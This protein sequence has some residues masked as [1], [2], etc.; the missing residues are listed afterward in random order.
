MN[1]EIIQELKFKITK[2]MTSKAI[3]KRETLRIDRPAYNYL[4]G[5]K[6]FN[7]PYYEQVPNHIV[8]H[9]KLKPLFRH[10]TNRGQIILSDFQIKLNK[11]I[12]VEIFKRKNK[13]KIN[14]PLL[15]I[16]RMRKTSTQALIR[17]NDSLQDLISF[18]EMTLNPK[19]TDN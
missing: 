19:A 15:I 10:W 18:N 12:T 6:I 14:S 11:M 4:I 2:F 16:I 13:I 17:E 8:N 3:V 7:H 9:Y 5:L 1:K